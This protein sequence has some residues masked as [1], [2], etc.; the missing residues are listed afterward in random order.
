MDKR[1]E[2][3]VVEDSLIVFGVALSIDQIK[4]ILGIVLLVIQ[5]SLIL[6][7]G[8]KLAI[9]HIKNKDYNNAI[10]SI[11]EMTEKIQDAIDK[12]ED[13]DGKRKNSK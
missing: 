1:I 13:E 5:I 2:F 11:D 4:T 9:N 3:E 7:K 6:Y 12:T 10:K 8:I